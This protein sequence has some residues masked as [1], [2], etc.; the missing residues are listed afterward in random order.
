MSVI[1]ETYIC[2]HNILVFVD[3]LTNVSFTA[4]EKES[5]Y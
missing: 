5:D 3:I 1:S 4:R 2:A